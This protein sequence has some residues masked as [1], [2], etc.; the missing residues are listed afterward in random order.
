MPELAEKIISNS[1]SSG[2]FYKEL[3]QIPDSN[4]IVIF[5]PFVHILKPASMLTEPELIINLHL[6]R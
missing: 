6:K 3:N 1:D 5:S 4:R 2:F